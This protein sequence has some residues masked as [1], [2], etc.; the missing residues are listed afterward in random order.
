MDEDVA[1]QCATITE[2]LEQAD[3]EAPPEEARPDQAQKAKEIVSAIDQGKAY[4]EFHDVDPDDVPEA[5]TKRIVEKGIEGF[6]EMVSEWL[7]KQENA[8]EPVEEDA[9]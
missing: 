7:S 9:A 6:G 4:L 5:V 1:G 2:T 8:A 3:G